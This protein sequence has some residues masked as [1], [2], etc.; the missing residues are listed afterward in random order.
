MRGLMAGVVVA[1]VL[2]IIPGWAAAGVVTYDFS[3]NGY[4]D[5]YTGVGGARTTESA[6]FTGSIVL[7]TNPSGLTAPETYLHGGSYA[8]N[9]AGNWVTA[10]FTLNWNGQSFRPSDL[11]NPLYSSSSLGV[12]DND[13]GHIDFL[14]PYDALSISEGYE[15]ENGG[16]LAALSL[17]TYDTSWL[18]G[19]SFPEPVGLAPLIPPPPNTFFGA[20]NIIDFQNFTYSYSDASTSPDFQGYTGRVGLTSLTPRAASVPE[21]SS[22]ALVFLGLAALGLSRVRRLERAAI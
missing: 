18:S 6:A 12:Y 21:P 16:T 17:F 2:A 11:L 4:V 15:I 10:A 7:T 19:L 13:V 3:G 22:L 1:G 20:S 5:T 14:T 9:N 8:E